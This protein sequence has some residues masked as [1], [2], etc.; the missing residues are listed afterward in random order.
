LGR[1]GGGTFL[2]SYS[3]EVE[4]TKASTPSPER[5]QEALRLFIFQIPL[6]SS[7]LLFPKEG[8]GG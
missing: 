1:E 8:A 2:V 3:M 5:N 4:H 7:P 6:F